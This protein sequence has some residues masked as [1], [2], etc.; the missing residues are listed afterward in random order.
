MDPKHAFVQ[1]IFEIVQHSLVGYEQSER[2]IETITRGNAS[3]TI[4]KNMISFS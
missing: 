4:G 1:N 2:I 3:M